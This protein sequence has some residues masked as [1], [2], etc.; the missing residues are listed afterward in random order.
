MS[1]LQPFVVLVEPDVVVTQSLESCLREGGFEVLATHDGEECLR[2]VEEGSTPIDAVLAEVTMPGVG[3]REIAAVMAEYRPDV[4]VL[5]MASQPSSL[6]GAQ[7]ISLRS[8]SPPLD[9]RNTADLVLH[10]RTTVE[11]MM[12]VRTQLQA[13]RQGTKSLL[14]ENRRLRAEQSTLIA[15]VRALTAR[16]SPPTCPQC[17]AS[18]VAAI[19]Y[20]SER[21]N[22]RDELASG[23][24]IRGG[25]HRADGDPD[26]HCRDCDH[27]W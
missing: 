13:G 27:R 15:A 8:G 17:S 3:G 21:L 23:K 22:R 4:P 19:L 16:R 10:L 1:S 26:W 2:I 5:L 11:R 6:H 25:P 7:E 14:D 9:S 20:G 18:R 12:R 24:V